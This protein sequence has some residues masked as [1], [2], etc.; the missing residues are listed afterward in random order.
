MLKC[1]RIDYKPI[2]CRLPEKR[3][4]DCSTPVR[5]LATP[6]SGFNPVGGCGERRTQ[7]QNR[8]GMMKGLLVRVTRTKA[9]V[10]VIL[11][12]KNLAHIVFRDH[13]QVVEYKKDL[14]PA[15]HFSYLI[16]RIVGIQNLNH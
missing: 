10:H 13:A 6:D 1:L 3:E 16:W 14:N 9:A 15:P 11:I 12:I 7:K 5:A 8:E 4:F 2:N